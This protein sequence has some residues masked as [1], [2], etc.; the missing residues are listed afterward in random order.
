MIFPYDVH[1][2][3]V[4]SRRLLTQDKTAIFVQ[5]FIILN[6]VCFFGLRFLFINFL[7]IGTGWALLVQLVLFIAIGILLFRVVIFKED[8]KIQDYKDTQGDSFAK[9]LHVRKDNIA[10]VD[11]CNQK[12]NVFEYTNGCVTATMLFKF[13][14]NYDAVAKNTHDV[15]QAIYG[16]IC[17][18]NFEFST[19][20]M[21]EVFSNSIEY[22]RHIAQINSIKNKKLSLHLRAISNKS[23]QIANEQGNTD[24][25]YLTIKSKIPGEKEQLSNIITEILKILHENVTCFRSFEFLNIDT[26]LEFYREFYHIDAIDLAM[27]KAIELSSN[28]EQD[29]S[30]LITLYSLQSTDGKSYKVTGD[31]VNKFKTKEREI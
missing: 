18:Y 25:L 11:V 12:V 24:V 9:Y 13:G 20:T 27:L 1:K 2:R 10:T 7:G 5:L 29:Y 8:E 21:P 15:L 14:S 22:K 4:N 28:I 3:V 16:I 26:L 30:N 17:L 31:S 19:V 23:I 6:I